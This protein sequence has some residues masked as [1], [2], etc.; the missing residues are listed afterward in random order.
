[1]K[2]VIDRF[3]GDQSQVVVVEVSWVDTASVSQIY[4]IDIDRKA[5]W[6][7]VQRRAG[8]S[9][10]LND[11]ISAIDATFTSEVDTERMVASL[12]KMFGR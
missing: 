11:L 10:E 3:E 7:D 9:V 5:L 2:A 4:T 8:D 6:S 1:M 12:V